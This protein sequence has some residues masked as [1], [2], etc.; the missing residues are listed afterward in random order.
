[1]KRPPTSNPPPPAK[2]KRSNAPPV[3]ARSLNTFTSEILTSDDENRED[4]IQ[5]LEFNKQPLYERLE[6][7]LL[8]RTSIKWFVI[9]KIHFFRMVTAEEIET[10]TSY[11]RSECMRTLLL[12]NV[13]DDIQNALSKVKS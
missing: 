7:H 3:S 8:E 12:E 5:F 11:F 4:L 9:V 13:N 6:N 1:M 2:K 10:C